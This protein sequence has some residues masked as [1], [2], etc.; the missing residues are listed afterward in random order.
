MWSATMHAHVLHLAPAQALGTE[1]VQNSRTSEL[2]GRV[3]AGS[4]RD[5]ALRG[6]C[7]RGGAARVPASMGAAFTLVQSNAARKGKNWRPCHG[8]GWSCRDS[9][10]AFL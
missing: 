1:W 6:Q 8:A 4:G 2:M 5:E 3:V 9:P 10:L 7:A